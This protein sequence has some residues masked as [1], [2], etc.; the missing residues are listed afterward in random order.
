MRGTIPRYLGE[1]S[2][3]HAPSDAIPPLRCSNGHSVSSH[4]TR[5]G[6]MTKRNTNIQGT[7][8]AD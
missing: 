3:E 1:K 2:K 6:D 5:D 8:S 7:P 4:R